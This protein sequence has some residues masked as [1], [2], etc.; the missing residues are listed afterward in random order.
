MMII[1]GLFS[2]G[3]E[4]VHFSLTNTTNIYTQGQE[5]GGQA[6]AALLSRTDSGPV[7]MKHR[8]SR[9][10][11]TNRVTAAEADMG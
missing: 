8:S 4:A 7:R 9:Q 1:I 11:S 3:G 5:G 2:N 6:T 10:P